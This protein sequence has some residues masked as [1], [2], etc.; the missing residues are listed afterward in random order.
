MVITDRAA[1]ARS[2]RSAES[3][4]K[5]VTRLPAPFGIAVGTAPP[6][7]AA[8]AKGIMERSAMR[9]PAR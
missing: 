8:A 2:G 6:S 9:A 5:F 3:I 7:A 1:T 4:G